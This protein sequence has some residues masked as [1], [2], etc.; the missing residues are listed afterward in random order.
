M[1][2]YAVSE[3]HRVKCNEWKA[4]AMTAVLSI[5]NLR[6]DFPIKGHSQVNAV[7]GVSLQIE[8][9]ETVGLVGESGSGKTTLGRCAIHL[10]EPTGGSTVFMGEDIA[11]FH[12]SEMKQFRSRAQIVFQD[13][14]RFA[15]PS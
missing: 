14:V 2:I 12:G 1:D 7:N 8:E 5:D 6:K 3:D 9:G 4:T 11:K 15:E 13:P 10:I